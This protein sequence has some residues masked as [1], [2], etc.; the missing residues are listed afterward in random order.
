MARK[1]PIER[2]IDGEPMDRRR[3][4]ETR[5]K[6]KGFVRVSVMVPVGGERSVRTLAARLRE[7]A[8][9]GQGGN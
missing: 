4:Y 3:R 8:L 5:M 6:G 7:A 9:R 1:T 2:F